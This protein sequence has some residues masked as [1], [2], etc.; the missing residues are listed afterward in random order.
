MDE[1]EKLRFKHILSTEFNNNLKD[2]NDG[3][4]KYIESKKY[5]KKQFNKLIIKFSIA[6]L[7]V[8]NII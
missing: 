5:K 6:S 3:L 8:N 2:L 1:T 7:R 4:I